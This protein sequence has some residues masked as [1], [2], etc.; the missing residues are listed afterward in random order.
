MYSEGVISKKRYEE[1]RNFPWDSTVVYHELG[2]PPL[3]TP[4]S[5]L[6][7]LPEDIQRKTM[8][9]HIPGKAMPQQT[10]LTLA[11]FG[12]EHTRYFDSRQPLFERAYEL[13]NMLKHMDITENLHISKAQ[14]FLNIGEFQVVQKGEHIIRKA[15]PGLFLHNILRQRFHLQ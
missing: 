12:M 7:S 11:R 6:N 15:P 3:H 2:V 1:F 14:E 10:H 8:V 13:L 9:Y 4:V 5:F